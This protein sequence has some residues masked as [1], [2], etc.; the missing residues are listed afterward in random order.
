MEQF[1]VAVLTL[2]RLEW[3]KHMGIESLRGFYF[4]VCAN[5][6]EVDP[7]EATEY[8]RLTNGACRGKTL[9]E[10]C[11]LVRIACLPFVSRHRT[12]TILDP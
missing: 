8:V 9:P 5:V 12:I 1:E 2:P 7:S 4:D 6:R 10:S 3:R 11:P